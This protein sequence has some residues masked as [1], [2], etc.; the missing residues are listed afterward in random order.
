MVGGPAAP[1]SVVGGRDTVGRD[2]DS[3]V[4]VVGRIIE[5]DVV[6]RSGPLVPGKVGPPSCPP[7]EPQAAMATAMRVAP[8]Y[9]AHRVIPFTDRNIWL[10]PKRA[11]R[12]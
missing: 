6:E 4:V 12:P 9:T 5:V 11:L 7:P 10:P 2:P 3:V 8:A 1:T